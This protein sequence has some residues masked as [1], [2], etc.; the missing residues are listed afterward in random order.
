MPII[1]IIALAVALK[2]LEVWKFVD[3]SWWYIVGL[4]GVAFI[5]FEFVE[6]IFGL[7]KRKAHNVD[8]QRR[9][10]RVKQTFTKKK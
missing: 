8:A 7:D 10:D 9:K 3:L 1:I 2:L 5:W 6:K 4:M